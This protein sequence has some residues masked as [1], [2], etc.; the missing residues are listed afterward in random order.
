MG[1][2]IVDLPNVQNKMEESAASKSG[3]QVSVSFGRFE[4][5]DTLSWE[6]WSSFSHN[7]YLEEV[8]KCSTPGS[9]AQKKAYFEAHYKKIAARKAELMD[10]EKKGENDGLGPDDPNYEEHQSEISSSKAEFDVIKE[11][12]TEEVEHGRN[13]IEGNGNDVDE[14]EDNGLRTSECE[15]DFVEAA[16]SDLDCKQETSKLDTPEEIALV[17]EDSSSV[18]PLEDME[19]PKDLE[20]QIVDIAK[21]EITVKPDPPKEPQKTTK[22]TTTERNM[23]NMKKKPVSN[24][25]RPAHISTPKV[26]KP[27]STSTVMSTSRP[28]AKKQNVSSL[29]KSQNPPGESRKAAPKA[30]HMSLSQSSVN[31]DS[32]S[33]ATTRRSFIMEKMGDKDIVKRAFKTFQSSYYLSKSSN[34]DRSP[35]PKEVL[36]KGRERK[37]STSVTPSKENAGS[38]RSSTANQQSAKSSPSFGLRSN[39]RAERRKEF[40]KKLEDKS[41][42]KEAE[43][44]RLQSKSKEEKD[45]EIKKLRQSLNFKATPMPRFYKGQ[46]TSKALIEKV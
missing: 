40:S 14:A 18:K 23:S 15:N 34:E 29:P 11:K 35:V 1:E 42:A 24:A 16:N 10:Q 20:D 7:K 39:E 4:N 3:L 36:A 44:T 2:S 13:L 38:P 43:Q 8:G 25:P 9:V 26:S 12:P 21:E 5:D 32:A 22:A 17:D 33:F 37:V 31:S 41:T 30:L 46:G 19:P 45:A 6:K 28:S 27:S